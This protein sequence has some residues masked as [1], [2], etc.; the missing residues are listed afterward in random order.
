MVV[1]IRWLMRFQSEHPIAACLQGSVSSGTEIRVAARQDRLAANLSTLP[2]R[3]ARKMKI[4]GK[5]LMS[6]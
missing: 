6:C 4:A 2:A 3:Q 1:Y 5:N